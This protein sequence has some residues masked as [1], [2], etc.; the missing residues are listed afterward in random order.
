MPAAPD[1]IDREAAAGKAGEHKA[2]AWPPHSERERGKPRGRFRDT[3]KDHVKPPHSK[4]SAI[5]TCVIT[6][7]LYLPG[8]E[9]KFRLS[10]P[11]SHD[12]A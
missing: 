5:S 10:Y 7:V 2:V 11:G 6:S 1:R 3:C 8:L 9:S 4:T 12:T